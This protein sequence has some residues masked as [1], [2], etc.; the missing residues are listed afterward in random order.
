MHGNTYSDAEYNALHA[1]A[2]QCNKELKEC[3]K[4]D[5]P[6]KTKVTDKHWKKVSGMGFSKIDLLREI[7]CINGVLVDRRN[8]Y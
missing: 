7:G 6:A 3:S 8:M 1:V 4:N 5:I 2:V